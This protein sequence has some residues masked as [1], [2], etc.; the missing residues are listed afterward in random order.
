ML[1]ISQH[2]QAAISNH[3]KIY[4]ERCGHSDYE[5]SVRTIVKCRGMWFKKLRMTQSFHVDKREGNLQLFKDQSRF[6]ML[7]MA[8]QD[9]NELTV[10]GLTQSWLLRF[11]VEG[12]P[13]RQ[14]A[15]KPAKQPW[16]SRSPGQEIFD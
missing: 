15:D 8:E 13:S 12:I 2:H 10:W 4:M 9:H 16:S 1:P 7:K 11:E 14:A 5:C 6:A 3:A